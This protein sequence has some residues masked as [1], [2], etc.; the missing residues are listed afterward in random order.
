M[1]TDRARM[2]AIDVPVA[3]GGLERET[4]EDLAELPAFLWRHFLH[5]I[6]VR[7]PPACLIG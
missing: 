4:L 2:N 1:I 6:L 7:T 5:L 3:L